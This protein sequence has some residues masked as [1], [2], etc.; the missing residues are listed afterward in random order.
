MKLCRKICVLILFFVAAGTCHAGTIA[1]KTNK[2]GQ[3]VYYNTITFSQES[4]KYEQLVTSI[5][6]KHSVP[7]KLVKAVIQVESGYDHQAISPVGA[8]GLMQLMPDTATRFG[9][10]KAFVPEQNIEGGVRY[11]KYLLKLFKSNT[12]LAVAAYNAGENRVK[13]LGGIPPFVETQ[14]YVR[15]VLA[16]YS[17]QTRYIPYTGV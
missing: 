13:Q 3:K 17:G 4:K 12:K 5:S 16:L 2:K 6:K 9:V 7:V 8:M 1:W 15:K 10:A 11:L 14:N